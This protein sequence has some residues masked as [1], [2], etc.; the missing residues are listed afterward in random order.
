MSFF[1]R[2]RLQRKRVDK[3]FKFCGAAIYDAETG[4]PRPEKLIL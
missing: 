4:F 2:D 1:F 3:C